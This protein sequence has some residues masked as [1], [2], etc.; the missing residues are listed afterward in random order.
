MLHEQRQR[1][2]SFGEDAEQYDRARPSYPAALVDELT[3]DHPE[4]VLDVGCGTGIAGSLFAERG[5]HVLGVEPDPRMAA[6]ARRR[7]LEVEVATFEAWDPGDRRF[8]LLVS[9]QAWHWVD[10]VRGAAHAAT[11]LTDGGRFGVFWNVARPP[12]D[13]K[14]SLDALYARL[15][16]DLD[17]HSVM[18]GH[19]D[20]QRFEL[21]SDGLEATGQFRDAHVAR[22]AHVVT[23]T[24]AAW[25]DQLPT[26]S[27][28]RVLGRDALAPL[29]AA[30]G[31]EIDAYGGSFEMRYDT[32][33][34]TAVRAASTT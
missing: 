21:A 22:F 34:V 9:G 31:A 6:I 2:D 7:G 27:D 12:E 4:H 19:G 23:Y 20:G 11:V 1:A 28:H 13:L 30:V 16:P 5:C 32:V 17:A 33:L 15:A 8:E 26:H 10:P 25:L 29:L 24:T 3:V 18:L 14:R